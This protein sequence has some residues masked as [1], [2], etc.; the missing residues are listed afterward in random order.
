MKKKPAVK[1]TKEIPILLSLL[2]VLLFVFQYVSLEKFNVLPPGVSYRTIPRFLEIIDAKK[3][4]FDFTDGL[5]LMLIFALGL[6]IVALELWQKRLSLFLDQV[7]ASEKQTL[8][9]LAISSLVLV[10]FYFAR[11]GVNW[12]ADAPQHICY[13]YITAASFARGEIPIW[14]NFLGSGTPYLQ[15]YG[16][17][18]FYLVGL[19]D[20]LSPD[21]F[22][23]L[24]LVLGGSHILS[25]IG[26]YLLVRFLTHSRKAGFLAGLAYVLSFWHTQQVLIMGRLP[27]SL[28]YALLPW[29]FYF[30]E[31][32][33]FPRRRA[34]AAA[35]GALTSGLLTFTHPGY[36]FWATALLGLYAVMRLI[37]LRRRAS[38]AAIC[39]YSLAL[40]TGGVLFGAFLTLGMWLER[41]DTGLKLG[42]HLTGV[43]GPTWHHV[44]VWS[45]FRV[46]LLPMPSEGFHW[47]GGYLGLSLILVALGGILACFLSRIKFRRNSLIVAGTG[48]LITTLLAFAHHLPPL[49]DL[50]V[51]QAMPAG[52][53]LLFV[54]FFLAMAVGTGARVLIFRFPKVFNGRLPTLLLIIILAD[55]GPTTFQH[56]YIPSDVARATNF[57]EFDDQ[58][59]SFFDKG[60]LPNYRLF[61]A[62]GEVHPYFAYGRLLFS[63]QTP[64]PHGFHPGDLL[65]VFDFVNPFERFLSIRLNALSADEDLGSMVDWELISTG[66]KMLNIKYLLATQ[67]NQKSLKIVDFPTHSPIL[68]SSHIAPF[69]ADSLKAFIETGGFEN[70]L[71]QQNITLKAEEMKMIEDVFPVSWII[72]KME[73]DNNNTCKQI[74]LYG[75]TP[76]TDL[77]TSPRVDLLSHQVWNQR[78]E[79]RVRISAPC[80][81]RLAYSF[82]PHLQVRVDDQVVSS[83]ETATR[84]I[85]LRLDPGEHHIV[86]EPRLSPLRR[87]LLLLD[88]LL[89]GIMAWVWIR[90]RKISL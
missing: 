35:A 19:V 11:G 66:I 10:R 15:F 62:R 82:S 7:F 85:A 9:L 61:W 72:K 37:P 13:A 51:V 24:K 79:M 34:S 16:S 80:F 44:L 54:V 81:A 31:R 64:L 40:L 50:T 47:Y 3:I 89:I 65:T 43:P 78:V 45:N 46:W 73:V 26:M 27:L 76:E 32:L 42:F 18:F 77:G 41:G 52:R 86:L 69:P 87:G 67:G 20:L 88:L 30:F 60:E 25:G 70:F 49:R 59:Q 36:A 74:L 48:L 23:S 2:G 56:L 53:Y 83:F 21:F 14:T 28:F 17:L 68:V 75:D 8:W 38:F 57:Q 1:R 6:C 29:P 58:A 12:G 63:G 33:R 4:N 84:F 55:L 71:L 5:L 90:E 22:L 39:R